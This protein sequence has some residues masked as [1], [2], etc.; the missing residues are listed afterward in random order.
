MS[1]R[2]NIAEA[3]SNAN[4]TSR[5]DRD[6]Q[7]RNP[8]DRGRRGF[9]GINL[10]KKDLPRREPYICPAGQISQ[11]PRAMQI[12]HPAGTATGSREIPLIGGA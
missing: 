5:R 12:K 10:S 2:T 7:S 8:P 6:G 3:E 1:G 11:K 4:K 9:R